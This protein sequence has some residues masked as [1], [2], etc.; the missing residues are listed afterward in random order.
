MSGQTSGENK[1]YGCAP[2]GCLI[3][4]IAIA[5]II[6]YF[7]IKPKLEEGGISFAALQ[8]KITVARSQVSD[9]ISAAQ[10]HL[11]SAGEQATDIKAA[12]NERFYEIKQDIEEK[13]PKEAIKLYED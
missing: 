1:K 9:N 2:L 6:F 5:V 11:N 4:V 3:I 8:E 10:G 7:L 13:M 12:T